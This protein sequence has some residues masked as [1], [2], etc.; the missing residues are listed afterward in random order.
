MRK[1]FSKNQIKEIAG[2]SPEKVIEIVNEGIASGEIQA[3]GDLYLHKVH[4]TNNST[5]DNAARYGFGHRSTIYFIDSSDK[6]NHSFIEMRS[7]I[8]NGTYI[9]VPTEISNNGTG[10]IYIA[11]GIA[12]SGTNIQIIGIKID[13]SFSSSS[14]SKDFNAFSSS[15][16]SKTENVYKIE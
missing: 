8:A 6:N 4:F 7:I 5:T 9:H 1:M 14:Y 12:A 2:S 13:S 11:T 16:L 15:G 3:G 10:G